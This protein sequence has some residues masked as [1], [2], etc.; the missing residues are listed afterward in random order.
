[1]VES[2]GFNDAK[3][4]AAFGLSILVIFKLREMMRGF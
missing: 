4:V 1:M 3:K 2:N